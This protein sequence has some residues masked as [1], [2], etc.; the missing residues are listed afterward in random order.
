MNPLG[1]HLTFL[2]GATDPAPA[3]AELS[4]ALQSA[5]VTHNDQGPSGFQLTLHVGR[6]SALDLPDYRLLADPQ[7]APF[8]RLILV[9]RFAASPPQ[10]LM[11][12]IITNLQLNPSSEPGAST[13]VLTGEDVSVMMDLKQEAEA[14][15]DMSYKAIVERVVGRYPDFFP[16]RFWEV[17]EAREAPRNQKE[18]TEHKPANY[19]DRRYLQELARRNG[20]VFYSTPGPE[21][22]SN[23][24]YFGPPE[25]EEA[26]QKALSVN[27]GPETNVE[28]I[29]FRFNTL[30]MN[31]VTFKNETGQDET[32][33]APSDDRAPL[34]A[35]RAEPRRTVF[36][37]ET[38][39]LD[40]GAARTRAQGMVDHS[41]DEAASATGTLNAVGYGALLRPR[42]IVGLRGA[43]FTHD[44]DWYVK[45]VSHSIQRGDY[46]QRFTLTREGTGA[47]SQRVRP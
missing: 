19:T 46:K 47:R 35:K 9:V 34:A 21:V 13:L 2:V 15:P 5:E 7:L 40:Q 10:V 38:G 31:K 20:Y 23:G 27:M 24:V 18:G 41:S 44:G 37:S 8:N 1:V 22:K 28:S 11:D 14:Y 32:L 17:R 42:G 4:E 3:S 30:A 36:F 39:G 6:S 26:P 12:G 43:G 16:R 25:H 33:D 45:S 29:N